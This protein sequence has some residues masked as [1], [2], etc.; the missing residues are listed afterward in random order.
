MTMEKMVKRGR[1]R[2]RKDSSSSS[3]L[4]FMDVR[5]EFFKVFLPDVSSQQLRV[6]PLFVKKFSGLVCK[7]IKLRCID[8]K[9]W[10]VD[11]EETQEGVFMKNG[12]QAF[13]DHHLLKLGEFLVFR[14]DGNSVFTVKIFRTHGC[15]EE[16][17]VREKIAADVKIEPL[18]DQIA[19]TEHTS[20]KHSCNSDGEG[21]KLDTSRGV[22]EGKQ[23]MSSR[24]HSQT[25]QMERDSEFG[26][27]R[28]ISRTQMHKLM[29]S[30]GFI[31]KNNIELGSNVMLCNEKEEK[32]PVKF[33]HFRD[34]RACIGTGW[35]A[36]WKDNRMC[37]GDKFK[38]VFDEGRGGK[39]ITVCKV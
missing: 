37:E 17:F 5:P 18:E 35:M 38:L 26:S 15:K 21:N 33:T 20:A 12:W 36:F 39:M 19:A 29:L 28:S 1:G 8:G 31:S 16:A 9:I 32:W 30:K 11:V 34:G 23:Q 25:V 6:P 24:F 3:Y 2:P 10:D 4:S 22:R 13:A 27:I 7:R 14:Y